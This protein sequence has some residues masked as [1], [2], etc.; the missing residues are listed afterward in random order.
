MWSKLILIN[1]NKQVVKSYKILI[2]VDSKPID[3]SRVGIK[4]EHGSG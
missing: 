2:C 4:A 3:G 1:K